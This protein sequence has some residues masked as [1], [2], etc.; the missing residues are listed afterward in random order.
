MKDINKIFKWGMIGLIAVS[1]IL[2]IWGFAV[3]FDFKKDLPVTV[4]LDWAYI[5]VVLAILA[6]VGVGLF[7]GI[8]NNPKSLVK[9]GIG[10]A[11]VVVVALLAYLIAPGSP[12]MGMAVQPSAAELKLTDTLLYIT[13]FVG[14]LAVV[15]I[16]AGEI[17]ISVRN[18][19]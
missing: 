4:L 15:A 9:L 7:V 1:V 19:K 11:A 18:K 12:A 17:L 6:V 5:M 2:L 14:G 8:K 3:G 10:L 16:I 13:Y